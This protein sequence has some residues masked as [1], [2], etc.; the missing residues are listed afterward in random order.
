MNRL[1]ALAAILL[2]GM[3]ALTPAAAP[4]A[5]Y[6]FKTLDEPSGISNTYARGAGNSGSAVGDYEDAKEAPDQ[7]V[8]P[9]SNTR[10]ISGRVKDSSG[11]PLPVAVTIKLAGTKIAPTQTASDGTFSF[12]GLP[13]GIY[14]VKPMLDPLN[15]YA[16][17]P[18]SRTVDV[19]TKDATK[20]KFTGTL[21]YTISGTVT[22]GAGKGAQ[23]LRGVTVTVSTPAGAK[24]G[25]AKTDSSGAFSLS[26]LFNGH[27]ILTPAKSGFFFAPKTRPVHVKNADITSGLEF[28][29]FHM[30]TR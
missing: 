2:A 22:L 8:T 19:R 3:L 15:P 6:A 13:K 21:T 1:T 12:S 9:T 4:A 14:T 5:G 24:V 23:P 28:H 26:W 7:G 29:A 25:S 17:T 20:V 10:S 27:Y 11:Q 18:A 30:P 16:F